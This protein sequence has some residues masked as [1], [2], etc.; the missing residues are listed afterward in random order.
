MRICIHV[1][2]SACV[3]CVG[4][5]DDD[6]DGDTNDMMCATTGMTTKKHKNWKKHRFSTAEYES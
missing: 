5:A 1:W 4:D 2:W 3:F 6:D